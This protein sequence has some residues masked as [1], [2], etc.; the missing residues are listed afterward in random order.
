MDFLKKEISTT[1]GLIAIF[2]ATVVLFGGAFTYYY[3][4]APTTYDY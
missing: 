4:T 2:G 3:R 1:K